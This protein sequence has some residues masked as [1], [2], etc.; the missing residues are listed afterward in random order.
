MTFE[1]KFE[2]VAQIILFTPF[3]FFFIKKEEVRLKAIAIYGLGV[4]GLF[5]SLIFPFLSAFYWI[6]AVI[7]AINLI[8]TK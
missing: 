7:F 3:A 5:L 8:T 4:L 1:Q 6:Y 2:L